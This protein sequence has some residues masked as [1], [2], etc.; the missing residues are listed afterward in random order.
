VAA[1]VQAQVVSDQQ[2]P[3]STDKLIVTGVRESLWSAQPIKRNVG[4]QIQRRDG[5]GAP[6]AIASRRTGGF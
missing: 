1:T 6:D 4:V 3:G 5:E 2:S